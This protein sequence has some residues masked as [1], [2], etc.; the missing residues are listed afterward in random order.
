LMPGVVHSAESSAEY[1]P[2]G[3][4]GESADMGGCVNLLTPKRHISAKTSASSPNSCLIEIEKLTEEE[5]AL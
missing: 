2:V 4:P 5:A 1:N 3:E